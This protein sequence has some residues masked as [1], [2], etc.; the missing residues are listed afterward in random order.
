MVVLKSKPERQGF[1]HTPRG[2]QQMFMY[3][4]YMFDRY[5]CI[6]S[7]CSLKTFAKMLKNF[8]FELH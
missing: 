3:Q 4:I 7:F 6:K 5:N 1:Y 2:D 8:N